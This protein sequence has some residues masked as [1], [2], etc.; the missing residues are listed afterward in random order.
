MNDD[1]DDDEDDDDDDDD[2]VSWLLMSYV[3]A[4]QDSCPVCT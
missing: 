2:D 1:D 4:Y 3:G